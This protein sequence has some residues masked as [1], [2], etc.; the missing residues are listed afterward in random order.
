MLVSII[1]LQKKYVIPYYQLKIN[2]TNVK[3]EGEE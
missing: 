3:K 2:K 1:S